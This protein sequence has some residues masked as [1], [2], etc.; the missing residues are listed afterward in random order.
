VSTLQECYA[1]LE[2]G[3]IITLWDGS[4]LHKRPTGEYAYI[5]YR[6]DPTVEQPNLPCTCD[7]RDSLFAFIVLREAIF[8][9]SFVEADSVPSEW[10]GLRNIIPAMEVHDES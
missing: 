6:I 1:A 4:T 5:P 8:E 10:A 3:F 2:K 7:D 9:P